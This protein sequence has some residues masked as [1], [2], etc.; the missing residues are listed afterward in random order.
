MPH[1]PKIN[2]IADAEAYHAQLDAERARGKANDE[3]ADM[4]L[5]IEACE[6]REERA[7]EK[8]REK[9]E[10]AAEKRKRK[11]ESRTL[12]PKGWL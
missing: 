6:L 4:Q 8:R 5:F 9:R 3:E 10:R 1:K 12:F 2:S 11:M 7:A